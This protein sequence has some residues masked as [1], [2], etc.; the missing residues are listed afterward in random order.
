MKTATLYASLTMPQRLR[1]MTSAFG[2]ADQEE[3]E[4]YLFKA[5]A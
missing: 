1:T 4:G 2:R 3:L 5:D